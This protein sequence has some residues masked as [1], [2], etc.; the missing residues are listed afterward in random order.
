MGCIGIE[1]AMVRRGLSIVGGI[2]DPPLVG[3]TALVLKAGR[4]RRIARLLPETESAVWWMP[5][6]LR[7]EGGPSGTAV[8][9]VDLQKRNLV[10]YDCENPSLAHVDF[11]AD[12]PGPRLTQNAEAQIWQKTLPTIVKGDDHFLSAM[13]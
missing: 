11:L 2:G 8:T 9:V 1:N 10:Q 13:Q 12:V 4:V 6:Q 3:L 5:N 7:P